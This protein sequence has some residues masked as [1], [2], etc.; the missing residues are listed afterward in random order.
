[1]NATSPRGA[2]VPAP[3]GFFTRL[4]TAAGLLAGLRGHDFRAAATFLESIHPERSL[5]FRL[6]QFIGWTGQQMFGVIPAALHDITFARPVQATPFWLAHGN[7][8]A[9]FPWADD[10]ATPVPAVVDT[11]VI[12]AGFTGASLGYFWAKHAPA[13]RTLAIVEMNDP[14]DGASGRNAGTIVMGRYYGMVHR[15]VLARL[16]TAKPELADAPRD[17]LAHGFAAAYCRAAYRNAEMIAQTIAA[18]GFDCDYARNGWIQVRTVDEQAA[19]DESVRLAEAHGFDDWSKLGPDEVVRRTG[20]HVEAAAGFSRRAG[21][22]H[23]AKWVWSLLRTALKS[24]TVRLYTRTKVQRIEDAGEH[25]VVHTSRGPIRAR[26]VV[27]ATEAYTAAL[28]P[29]FHDVI[30]PIQSQAAAGRGGPPRLPSEFTVSGALWFGDRRN[31]H[32]LFGTDATRIPDAAADQN[33]PSRFLTKFTLGEMM[34][35]TGPFAMEVTHEWSGAV[36]FTADE[37]PLVGLIDG[38]RQYLIGGMCGSGTGVAF[39]AGRC[40]VNRI[41]ARTGETDD[42]PPEFFAPSRLLDPAAHPWPNL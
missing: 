12:G 15:S 38:K 17:R 11:V 40:V 42:Y 10:P 35:Y 30:R 27:N 1:M 41:L 25:Y 36:G 16:R 13:G 37:Y 24:E 28:H 31:D 39:N 3:A 26:H 34:A 7:P 9:N 4:K 19:L 22:F 18:E 8:L 21:T 23:P 14:A 32:V 5:P 29:R 2:P 20:L 33:R 6:L